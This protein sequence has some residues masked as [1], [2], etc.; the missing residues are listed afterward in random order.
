[1]MVLLTFSEVRKYQERQGERRR[2]MMS[3]LVP[4]HAE[5]SVGAAVRGESLA[6]SAYVRLSRSRESKCEQDLQVVFALGDRVGFACASE[7]EEFWEQRRTWES[8]RG[9]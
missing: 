5:A 2:E 6:G 4:A 8:I 9:R 1:M 3:G 7:A